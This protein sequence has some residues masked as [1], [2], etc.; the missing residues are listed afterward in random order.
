MVWVY[1]DKEREGGKGWGHVL[2]N[3]IIF[4][5]IWFPTEINIFL[6]FRLSVVSTYIL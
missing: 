1:G 2:Y 3:D 5:K 6:K 4:T